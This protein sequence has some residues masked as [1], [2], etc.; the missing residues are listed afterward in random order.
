MLVC[1][2]AC[3]RFPQQM[4]GFGVKRRSVGVAY[5]VGHKEALLVAQ[6]LGNNVSNAPL[7]L[8]NYSRLSDWIVKKKSCD[9]SGAI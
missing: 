3:N 1:D 2:H 4:Q 9:P 7:N 8:V 6:N 5:C